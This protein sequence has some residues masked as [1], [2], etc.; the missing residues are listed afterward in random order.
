MANDAPASAADRLFAKPEPMKPEAVAPELQALREGPARTLY[1]AEMQYPKDVLQE[2]AT[3][4]NPGGAPEDLQ[5]QGLEFANIAAD[6]G[7]GSADL[8]TLA[9]LA[10]HNHDNMPTPNALKGMTI[11]AQRTLREVYGDDGYERAVADAAVVKRDA[12]FHGYLQRTGLIHHPTLMLRWA[13]L[14]RAE[15]LKGRHQ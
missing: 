5:R 2:L 3:A 1:P 8:Q 9:R 14:G 15:R 6:L 10:K 12:R 13:E 11:A 4:T 7:M